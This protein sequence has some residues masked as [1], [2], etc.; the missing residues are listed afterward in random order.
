MS[1]CSPMPGFLYPLTPSVGCPCAV[2]TL[3]NWP[4]P[5]PLLSSPIWVPL[6]PCSSPRVPGR[7]TLSPVSFASF[8][9]PTRHPSCVR[10][11]HGAKAVERT[12]PKF[13]NLLEF[14]TLTL[15]LWIQTPAL[16]KHLSPTNGTQPSLPMACS[17]KVSIFSMEIAWAVHTS[18]TADQILQ[19]PTGNPISAFQHPQNKAGTPLPRPVF[20]S[21]L[22]MKPPSPH[23]WA[24][25][26][27]NPLIPRGTRWVQAFRGPCLPV[28]L[29]PGN[30]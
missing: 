1:R 19:F 22:T 12:M 20:G 7:G 4:C 29:C 9:R 26:G 2:N 21:S 27:Q 16:K 24:P 5:V 15:G 30:K 25:C 11:I 23:L 18:C 17:L 3:H 6:Y 28:L 10:M 13:V 14:S 8:P